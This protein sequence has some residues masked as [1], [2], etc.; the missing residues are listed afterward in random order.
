M[1]PVVSIFTDKDKKNRSVSMKRH[2]GKEIIYSINHLYLS[3]IG[4]PSD[5]FNDV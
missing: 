5:L 2:D 1:G 4:S 3:E